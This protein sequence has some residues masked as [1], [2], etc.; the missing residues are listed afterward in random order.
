MFKK[1]VTPVLMAALLPAAAMAAPTAIVADNMA[2]SGSMMSH[3]MPRGTM[4]GDG[5]PYYGAPDLVA[6]SSLV[7]AGGAPQH[8]SIVTAPPPRRQQ[9]RE[10]RSPQTDASVRSGQGR[11]FRE[12]AEL[13]RR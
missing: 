6:A 1:L 5:I 3:G 4:G 7:A 11:E 2:M 13:R 10:R 9:D 8:F 12:S